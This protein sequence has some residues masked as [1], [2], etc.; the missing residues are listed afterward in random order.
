VQRLGSFASWKTFALG[1]VLALGLGACAAARTVAWN[2]YERGLEDCQNERWGDCA[3]AYEASMD[4]GYH[5]PGVHA[6]YGV[7]LVR[8]GD[9][10][11]AEA[12]FVEEVSHHPES[13]VLVNKLG[14]F[15]SEGSTEAVP[16]TQPSPG[17]GEGLEAGG[18]P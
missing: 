3:Q 10:G 15:L 1:L 9:L 18:Q 16:P 5:V 11:G 17:K 8:E 14:M 6:D 4:T 13:A 2:H 12:Q 7:L